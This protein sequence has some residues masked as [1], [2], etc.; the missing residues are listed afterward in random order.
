MET[1]GPTP[2][3]R[4]VRHQNSKPRQYFASDVWA[5]TNTQGKV[6]TYE[7]LTKGK[8]HFKAFGALVEGNLK[9]E[10]DEKATKFFLDLVKNRPETVLDMV[11]DSK[12]CNTAYNDLL[13]LYDRGT[14]VVTVQEP[15]ITSSLGAICKSVR[16]T[17]IGRLNQIQ[18]ATSPASSVLHLLD[19]L[20]DNCNGVKRVYVTCHSRHQTVV[21]GVQGSACSNTLPIAVRV[22]HEQVV[23][24][25]DLRLLEQV[26]KDIRA[27]GR[28]VIGLRLDEKTREAVLNNR[29][30]IWKTMKS[31]EFNPLDWYG[32]LYL[33]LTPL[34]LKKTAEIIQYRVGV[35]ERNRVSEMIKQTL[36]TLVRPSDFQTTESM[37][38]AHVTERKMELVSR[39]FPVMQTAL[40]D[41]PDLGL[42][43]VI[44]QMENLHMHLSTL[45]KQKGKAEGND[46][47]RLHNKLIQKAKELFNCKEIDEA[48]SDMGLMIDSDTHR[49][50]S[51]SMYHLVTEASNCYEKGLQYFM[52]Q[53]YAR[54]VA[55]HTCQPTMI[56]CANRSE[57]TVDDSL[58][59]SDGMIIRIT[60]FP[61]Q[62]DSVRGCIQ[63][64]LSL[65]LVRYHSHGPAY[66]LAHFKVF[67][68]NCTYEGPKKYVN[69]LKTSIVG[70]VI[71]APATYYNVLPVQSL[72]AN[73]Y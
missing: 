47:K 68:A 73:L 63:P 40:K 54:F 49:T 22:H 52:H 14:P 7:Y 43:W 2:M 55:R 59:Y 37:S 11:K 53:T 51:R 71:E 34:L 62:S 29:G 66:N 72:N 20:H 1:Q 44:Y 39:L 28:E 45:D 46:I 48:L 30:W 58:V 18:E 67:K 6:Q 41:F 33:K 56:L 17:N 10:L 60:S 5:P 36:Q 70:K 16:L 69:V 61:Y 13:K 4:L 12:N 25:P 35:M 24:I 65:P 9:G 15:F 31:L 8:H 3:E 42:V 23:I 38:S 27:A 57:A 50:C 21:I 64:H 32:I 26:I 19:A